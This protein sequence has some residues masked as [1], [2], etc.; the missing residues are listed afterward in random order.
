[1]C[2]VSV[3]YHSIENNFFL[4]DSVRDTFDNNH[5]IMTT[6]SF[7]D[8]VLTFFQ[9]LFTCH[10]C[11]SFKE[12]STLVAMNK[13]RYQEERELLSTESSS[14]ESTEYCPICLDTLLSK[15]CFVISNCGHMLHEDCAKL[16]FAIKMMCPLCNE[17]ISKELGSLC[18]PKILT[19]Y[20]R[21]NAPQRQKLIEENYTKKGLMLNKKMVQQDTV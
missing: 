18:V 3:D 21:Y 2:Y 10:C 17:P 16:W 19:R 6:M 11:S 5:T 12:E 13:Q 9:L 1:M 20:V 14:D 15:K 8:S 7:C 4:S